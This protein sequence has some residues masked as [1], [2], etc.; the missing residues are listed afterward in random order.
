MTMNGTYAADKV[1]MT[2]AGDIKE[3][4]LPGGKAAI[5]MTISSERIGDC[6]S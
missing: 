1:S 5:E 6:K 3:E 4:K 2:L